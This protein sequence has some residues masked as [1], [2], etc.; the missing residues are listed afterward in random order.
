MLKGLITEI[1]WPDWLA[2]LAF[3]A[4]WFGYAFYS[5]YGQRARQGLVGLGHQYRLHWARQLLTREVRIMDASLIGNLQTSVSFYAN[6][7][8]YIIAGLFAVLGTLDKLITFTADLPFATH[9]SRDLLEFKLLLLFGVFV[10][11]YFKFTWSLRQFNLLSILLGAAPSPSS[12]G[13]PAKREQD[14][15]RLAE[16]NSLAGDEFNRGIRAY[17]F[18]LTALTWVVSPWLFLFSTVVVVIVLYRRDYASR[19]AA[20]LAAGLSAD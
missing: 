14:A 10:V 12:P 8:I 6:T 1:A 19:I 7:T 16:V 9:T 13:D 3:A 11:A 15:R 18:G 17:Y 5:E 2:L 4:A 20:T